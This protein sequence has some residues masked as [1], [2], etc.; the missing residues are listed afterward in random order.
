MW[1]C[2]RGRATLGAAGTLRSTIT[3][4]A[5]F[6]VCDGPGLAVVRTAEVEPRDVD[7]WMRAGGRSGRREDE[8]ECECDGECERECKGKE[9]CRG[10]RRGRRL[11]GGRDAHV[12]ALARCTEGERIRDSA[13]IQVSSEEQDRMAT[14]Q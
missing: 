11:G 10:E 4:L 6:S 5:H 12:G 9:T 13:T 1:S 3:H 8:D 7:V 2:K 14:S